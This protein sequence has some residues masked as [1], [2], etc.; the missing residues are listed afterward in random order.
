MPSPFSDKNALYLLTILEAIE[1]IKIYSNGF[2]TP[3]LLFEAKDQMPY[4]VYA[5][6]CLQ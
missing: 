1:K 2:D 4:N 6:Y 5:T 3:E